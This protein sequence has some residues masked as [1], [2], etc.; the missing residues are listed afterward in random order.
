[1]VWLFAT[2]ALALVGFW[3]IPRLFERHQFHDRNPFMSVMPMVEDDICRAYEEGGAEKLD[4]Q[5]KRLDEYLSGEHI[6]LDTSGRDLVTGADRAELL[7]PGK[8]HNGPPRL[9]DGRMILMSPKR[10]DGGKYRFIT[11]VEPW[12]EPINLFPYYTIVVLVVAALGA[13]LAWHLVAPIRS[14]RGVVDRFGRGERSARSESNRK[15]EIGELA[16]A[17]DEMASRIET[18][19]AAERRLLQDVSHE[20]RSPL[21][22]LDVAVDLALASD[23]PHDML[24]RIRRDIHRLSV[25][26]NELVQLTRAEGDLSALDLE[27]ISLTALIRDLA[28]DAA[29]EAKA[30]HC[31]VEIVALENAEVIGDRELLRRAFENI[32]RNA[33]RHTEPG[34]SVQIGLTVSGTEATFS[35]RD[36]GPGVPSELLDAIFQPFFR[37]EGHRSRESGGVGLG[38]AIVQR[39]VKLHH[40][41]VVAEND[42]PGLK[43]TISLPMASSAAALTLGPDSLG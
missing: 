17:F 43:V 6:L 38:L 21:T 22:R 23:T 33:I 1:M 10:G 30:K 20:L 41:K 14:L 26:V 11:L 19:L 32:L 27:E 7:K 4:I 2:L 8:R 34:T 18:L 5:L 39:S 40:G 16:H 31:A 37:V 36:R 13:I 12:F 35:V 24:H 9:A 15:D 42:N 3:S 28:D 25:L 29:L